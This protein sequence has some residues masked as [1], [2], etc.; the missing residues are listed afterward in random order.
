MLVWRLC[1]RPHADLAGEGGRLF[2]GRW[3][4]AGRPV[5]YTADSPAL[6]ILEV[7]VHLDLPYDLLPSDYV[8]MT[9]EIEPEVTVETAGTQANSRA[10]GDAWLSA[11][12]TAILRVPSV[13][14]PRGCNLLINPSH[15]EAKAAIILEIEDFRFDPRLWNVS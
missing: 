14:A 4:T 12:R 6:A 5:V 7:R 15:P 8:L 10:F 2:S 3:H 11:R 1:R 13:I 9:I